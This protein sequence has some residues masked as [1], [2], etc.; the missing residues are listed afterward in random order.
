MCDYCHAEDAIRDGILPPGWV[1]FAGSDVY[2]SKAPEEP[3][4]VWISWELCPECMTGPLEALGDLL[5]LKEATHATATS[6]GG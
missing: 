6:N 4:H 5:S 2:I 3:A 1:R